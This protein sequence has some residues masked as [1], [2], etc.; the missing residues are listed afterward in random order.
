MRIITDKAKI[1]CDIEVG[2]LYK[3]MSPSIQEW[4]K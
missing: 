1:I 3:Y 4:T 2:F